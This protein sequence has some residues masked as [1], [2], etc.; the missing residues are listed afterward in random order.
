MATENQQDFDQ[1]A[2][3]GQVMGFIGN[4]EQLVPTPGMTKREYFAGLAMQGFAQYSNKYE[5][6]V[7]IEMLATS[8]VQLADALIA[9]LNELQ[10]EQIIKKWERLDFN[11]VIQADV[12]QTVPGEKAFIEIPPELRCN[13]SINSIFLPRDILITPKGEHLIV[14]EVNSIN[15]YIAV[16]LKERIGMIKLSKNDVL[17]VKP[18]NQ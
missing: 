3:P 8:S 9:K 16:Y 11:F 2:F 1:Y 5:M 10:T 12:R 15:N 14:S 4:A 7:L 13:N 18:F 6:P 17:L